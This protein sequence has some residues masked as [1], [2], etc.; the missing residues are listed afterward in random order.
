MGNPI[1]DDLITILQPLFVGREFIVSDSGEN[2]LTIKNAKGMMP[3]IDVEIDNEIAKV[4][5]KYGLH[6]GEIAWSF[7]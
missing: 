7:F 2:S 4:G 6:K 1:L 5:S 3:L